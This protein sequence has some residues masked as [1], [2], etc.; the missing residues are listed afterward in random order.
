VATDVK[1]LNQI[2]FITDKDSEEYKK[3]FTELTIINDM[4]ESIY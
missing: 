3:L 4:I 1:R 2:S